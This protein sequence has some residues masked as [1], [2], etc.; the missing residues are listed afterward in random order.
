MYRRILVPVDGSA[1]SLLGLKQ[2]IGLARDQHARLRVLNVVDELVIAPMLMEPASFD[3]AEMLG[4]IRAEGRKV[5]ERAAATAAKAG[6]KAE[7]A[8]ID[9]R[10]GPV[11]GAILA[12][13]RRWGADV[14][15]MG[16]H[17]RRG[18]N[19]LLLGSDAERVLRD[20]TVPVLLVRAKQPAARRTKRAAARVP[21][22]GKRRT[23]RGSRRS[24][25]F[26]ER[27]A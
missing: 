22:N 23:P 6:V 7:T 16:T 2:A 21:D 3:V 19:R 4:P 15:V 13:A 27:D 11:S 14:I 8:Q 12:D 9:S 1:P 20:A 5:L 25:A 24:Q 26:F 10:A 18:M 17:G